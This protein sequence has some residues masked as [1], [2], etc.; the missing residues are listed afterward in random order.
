MNT[1][2]IKVGFNLSLDLY[3]KCFV[4]AEKINLEV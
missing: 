1:V 4:I 2:R 3:K